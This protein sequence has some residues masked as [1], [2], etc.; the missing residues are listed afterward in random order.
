MRPWRPWP[1]VRAALRLGLARE[2]RGGEKQD[3]EAALVLLEALRED[4]LVPV[5][6]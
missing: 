3:W 4:R 6:G 2:C 1:L 5:A